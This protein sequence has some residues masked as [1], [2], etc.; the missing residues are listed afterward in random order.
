MNTTQH[1]YD[2]SSLTSGRG[3]LHGLPLPLND[4]DGGGDCYPTDDNEIGP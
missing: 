3:A 4:E 1:G 2:V